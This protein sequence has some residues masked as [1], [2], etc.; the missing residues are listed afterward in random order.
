M[1]RYHVANAGQCE[2]TRQA[3][4]A[5]WRA[6]PRSQVIRHVVNGVVIGEEPAA[7]YYLRT[8]GR[9][10]FEEAIGP[11]RLIVAGEDA[12]LEIHD[13]GVVGARLTALLGRGGLPRADELVQVTRAREHSRLPT[14]V[15][16][17]LDDRYVDEQLAEE[18]TPQRR[19]AIQAE[20]TNGGR[21]AAALAR[22]DARGAR[23]ELDRAIGLGGGR[24]R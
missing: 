5:A 9:A 2:T 21:A 16:D 14:G 12:A 23:V 20:L 11:E 8:T 13:S 19:D 4:N 17:V 15:R 18:D 6:L 7:D 3:I 10:D 1:T 22:K 24:A